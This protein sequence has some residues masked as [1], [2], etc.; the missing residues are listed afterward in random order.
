MFGL[1]FS[2]DSLKSLS[3]IR[4]STELR[5]DISAIR[6]KRGSYVRIAEVDPYRQLTSVNNP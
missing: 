3:V 1:L 4:E 5:V 6:L 2:I